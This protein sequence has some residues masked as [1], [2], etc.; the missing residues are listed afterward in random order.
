MDKATRH[1]EKKRARARGEEVEMDA[2]TESVQS[3]DLIEDFPDKTEELLRDMLVAPKAKDKEE[4][5]DQNL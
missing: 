5:E 3:E 4:E 2:D 1:A